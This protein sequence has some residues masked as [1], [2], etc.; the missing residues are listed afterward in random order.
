[1]VTG[2]SG[3]GGDLGPLA[4]LLVDMAFESRN[5]NEQIDQLGRVRS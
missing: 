1:M 4:S 5:L 3:G 2:G